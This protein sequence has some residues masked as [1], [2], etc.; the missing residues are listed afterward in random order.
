MS[1][2]HVENLKGLSSGGNANKV[3]IPTGQT[4]Y[5]PGHIV[6]TVSDTHAGSR[7]FST[8]S[9]SFAA[10]GLNVSITPT[11]S[12]SKIMIIVSSSGNNNDATNGDQLFYTLFR[13]STN[14]GGTTQNAGFG[15]IRG[16]SGTAVRGSL[17]ISYIDS[18]AT[19]SAVSYELY[20]RASNSRTTVEIAGTSGTRHSI[21]AMEIAQ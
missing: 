5:A 6:Q 4:L 12:D 21:I 20:A 19:T 13:D 9:T 7:L 14:I 1:T 11:S 2:L 8:S 10:S 15:Q 3:I 18:P 16:T 17:H